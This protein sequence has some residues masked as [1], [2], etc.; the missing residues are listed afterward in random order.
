MEHSLLKN[1]NVGLAL[2]MYLLEL[3]ITAVAIANG[4][5]R[6]QQQ[7][8]RCRLLH[9]VVERRPRIRRRPDAE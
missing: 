3:S 4:D 6:L 2:L 5:A 8:R 1:N 7:D 9:V